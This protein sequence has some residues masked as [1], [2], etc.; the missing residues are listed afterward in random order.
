[1]DLTKFETLQLP[2]KIVP[3]VLMD[4]VAKIEEEM[5]SVIPPVAAEFKSEFGC[6]ETRLSDLQDH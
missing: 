1:M 6:L 3:H 4:R 5:Y 2:Y